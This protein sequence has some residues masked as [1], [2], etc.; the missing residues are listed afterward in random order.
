MLKRPKEQRETKIK[1]NYLPHFIRKEAKNQ[2]TYLSQ[3]LKIRALL[4]KHKKLQFKN[5][6]NLNKNLNLES[7]LN[8][9]HS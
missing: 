5:Q 3:Q 9:N 8:R 2:N 6:Q 1:T 7:L 4:T